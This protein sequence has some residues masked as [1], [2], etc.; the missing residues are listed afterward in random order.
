M[1]NFRCESS[2]DLAI[3]NL[4]II[5]RDWK[6]LTFYYF[7]DAY[8]NFNSLVTDLFK[9]YKTRIWMSAINPASFASPSLGLQAP[10][11]IG[12][13]AVV[14]RP[15]QAERRPVA[16]EQAPYNVPQANRGYQ[17]VFAQP[18]TP[19]VDRLSMQSTAFQ[20]T[21][22]A[23]GYSPFNNAPRSTAPNG[24]DQY[25]GFPTPNDYQGHPARFPS[26]HGSG[27]THDASDFGRNQSGIP[28][29]DAW[30]NSFQGLSM[31][32]R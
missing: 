3:F 20:S 22:F 8:I 23:Y 29:N 32:T 1:Q 11:G 24:F 26:P 7:A 31:N 25:A 2:S 6:K 16:A 14:S 17:N 18:F 30:V 13:G 19:A 15:A 12:P 21:G 4:L 27:A 9:V 28:S 10:S 5:F